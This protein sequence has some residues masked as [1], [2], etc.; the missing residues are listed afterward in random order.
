MPLVA[1]SHDED[2]QGRLVRAR[3]SP[4]GRI[5]V[6]LVLGV[7]VFV[8][9]SVVGVMALRFI[10]PPLTPLMVQRMLQQTGQEDGGARP[11]QIWV[12]L[13]A[14]AP[15]LVRSVIAA[16]DSKFCRHGGFD[17]QAL[18]NAVERALAGA[19][20]PGGSTI[21]MQTAK[22]VFLLPDRSYVRKALEAYFTVLIELIWGKDRILEVYLNVAEWGPGIYGAEAAARHF[23]N[24]TGRV[25]TGMEAAQLAAML[26]NPRQRVPGRFDR[27]TKR[28]ADTIRARSRQIRIGPANTCP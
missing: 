5:V 23:F 19:R 21:S 6:W 28:Y 7:A 11:R 9:W 26:P 25:I 10:D 8:S 4:I 24:R 20:G 12:D 27:Q 2:V 15:D 3:L 18:E 14:H 17:W 22:N 13:S 16:E 1:D